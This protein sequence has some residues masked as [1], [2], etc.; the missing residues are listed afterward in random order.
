VSH[1]ARRQLRVR[2]SPSSLKVVCS[3]WSYK[4]CHRGQ[5][6]RSSQEHTRQSRPCL[7][8]WVRWQTQSIESWC[9]ASVGWIFTWDY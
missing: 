2:N 5:P 6:D 8:G 3:R 7:P 9:W 4:Y 1:S